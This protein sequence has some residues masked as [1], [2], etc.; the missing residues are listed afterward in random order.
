MYHRMRLAEA[1]D[2]PATLPDMR[3]F[4]SGSAPLS[5]GDFAGFA[6]RFGLEPLERYGLTETLIVTSNPLHGARL[7]GTVGTPLPGTQVRLAGDG[8]IE[9]RGPAVMHGYWRDAAASAACFRDGWFRTGDLGEWHASGHLRIAGRLKELIIVGGS[10]VLPGE[11]EHALAGVDGVD[12]LAAAGLDDAD[13]GE[14]VC[15]FVVASPGA[16]RAG[17][18]AALRARAERELAAYKRPGSYRFV[19]ALPR[20]AMGKVDRRALSRAPAPRA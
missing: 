1:D 4:V 15:A 14:V 11:V 3:L 8:E 12:E 13:R 7:P 10:N 9:V 2:L 16:D 5:P 20:N 6:A 18:E 19:E 17:V